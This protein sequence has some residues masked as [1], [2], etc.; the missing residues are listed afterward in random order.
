MPVVPAAIPIPVPM[1]GRRVM[2]RPY[3]VSDAPAVGDAVRE[4]RSAL[5]PW[6]PWSETHQTIEESIEFCARSLAQ[7]LLRENMNVGIFARDDGRYLGGSGYHHPDWEARCFELGYW[8]RTTAVG[9]GYMTE[10]VRVLTRVAFEHLGANRVEI[11]CDSR[12]ERSR[13]VAERCGY[14]LEATL[15]RNA[16]ATDGHLRDTLVFALL[17]ED[18][19]RLLPTWA[20][21]F[22]AL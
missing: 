20:E 11:R 8:L 4:S 10:T 16:I 7:W 1:L 2:L 18:F 19:D 22:P 9:R 21:A 17:R 14:P 6:M 15:H 3:D 12:N 13:H 5:R